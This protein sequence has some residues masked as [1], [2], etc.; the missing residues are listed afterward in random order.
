MA[1]K[2]AQATGGEL[3]GSMD[4]GPLQEPP[5]DDQGSSLP[6]GWV[7]TT[8]VSRGQDGCFFNLASGSQ[9]LVVRDVTKVNLGSRSGDKD[10][11]YN[12]WSGQF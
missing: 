5:Y 11:C 6:S 10:S 9:C 3:S 7:P 12:W 8:S 4:M 1:G 2:L